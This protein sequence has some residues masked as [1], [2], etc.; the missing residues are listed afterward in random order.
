MN[1]PKMVRGFKLIRQTL[2]DRPTE[3]NVDDVD[4]VAAKASKHSVQRMAENSF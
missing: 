1:F 4:I 3:V 2:S